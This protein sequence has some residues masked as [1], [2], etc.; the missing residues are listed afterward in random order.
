MRILDDAAG[1]LVDPYLLDAFQDL[2][3]REPAVA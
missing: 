2:L 3:R 1:G